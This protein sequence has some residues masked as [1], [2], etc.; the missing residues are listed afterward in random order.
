MNTLLKRVRHL[1]DRV[2]AL[3]SNA[4][5]PFLLWVRVY[6]GWQLWQSG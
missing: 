6:W 4:Q 2:F 5:S 3:V 1:H